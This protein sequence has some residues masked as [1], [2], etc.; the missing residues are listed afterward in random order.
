MKTKSK[1][2]GHIIRGVVYAVFLSVALIAASWAFDSPN[3]SYKPAVATGGYDSTAKSPSQPRAFSFAERV[4]YQRAIEDVYWRHRIWPKD[5]PNPKPSLD[6]V[7]FQAQLQKKVEGY[8]RDSLM[9]QERWQKPITA[10]QLQAEMDRMARDTKEPGV[11]RELFEALGND[12]A[13]IAECLARPILSERLIADFSTQ[14]ETRH[15]ESQQ[16]DALRAMSVVTLGQVVYSLPRI[17]VAGDPP[18]ID[19]WAATSTSNVPSGRTGHTAVWTG[20]EMIVWGGQGAR[21]LNTGGRY[22]PSTDTWT[23]T[24]TTNAPV[25]REFHTAVW[26][27]SEMIVWGGFGDSSDVNTGG[28]YNPSTDTW[29]ATSTSN[30]PS[31]RSL[32]AAVWTGS[33]MIVWGGAS[34]NTGGRY[35]PSSNSW[36]ATSTTNAPSARYVDTAVWTGSEMIV[37]GGNNVHPLNTGGRYNPSTN[38]WIAT[39]TTNAPS[40]RYWHTAIWTGSEMIVWGG[41]PYVNTGGRYNPSTDSWTATS[42]T[43]APSSRLWHTAVWTG[44]GMIVWGGQAGQL[45]NTGR[46]YDPEHG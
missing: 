41:I 43:N 22:D 2:S 21:L 26:T 3:K 45:F 19:Q 15:V 24:S 23:A 1:I 34:D 39:N 10:A 28:R 46:R 33:A 38:I 8:L 9:L 30:A 18:C 44:S 31:A 36:T 14:E 35:R 42:T 40:A 7:M 16:T 6:A 37:W 5:N 12:P 32:H 20:S 13:V 17:A 25:R 4:A 27:G 11:L 29:T